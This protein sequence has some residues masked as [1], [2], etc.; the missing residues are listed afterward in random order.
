[1]KKLITICLVVIFAL[2][3]PAGAVT[4]NYTVSG[5]GA[6]QF[7]GPVTPPEGAPHSVD[8]WGYPGDTVEL[9]T[10]TGTLDLTPGTYDLKINT[11]LWGVDYTYNG[12]ATAW[13]YPANWPDLTFMIDATRSITIGAA[14]GNISQDGSL[15]TTWFDDYLSFSAGPMAS[16]YVQG[17][18]VDITPL[19][20]PSANVENFGSG[21]PPAGGFAQPNQDVMARF[22]V[23]LIPEPATIGLLCFGA[24]SLIRRKR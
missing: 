19:S 24:L 15:K 10:Y 8:G 22:D 17:Y 4:I 14:T 11:L 21:D 5:W 18:Q 2:A 9:V 13:D 20:L 16:L 6:T 1:M 12:T 7:P 3:V 23:T